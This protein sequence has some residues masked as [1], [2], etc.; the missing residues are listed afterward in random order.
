MTCVAIQPLDKSVKGSIAIF[1]PMLQKPRFQPYI[2]LLS[3]PAWNTGIAPHWPDRASSGKS[4]REGRQKTAI[5]G[6]EAI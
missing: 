2:E 1:V 6:L 5:D 4:R 3:L